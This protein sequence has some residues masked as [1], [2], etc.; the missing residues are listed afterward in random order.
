MLD[1]IREL[2]EVEVKDRSDQV[3]SMHLAPYALHR[4]LKSWIQWV[5]NPNMMTKFTKKELEDVN[6]ELSELTHTSLVYD[7]KVTDKEAETA[8]KA[9]RKEREEIRTFYV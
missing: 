2:L 9:V 7:L 3:G 6:R 1:R 8:R 5:N 4:S